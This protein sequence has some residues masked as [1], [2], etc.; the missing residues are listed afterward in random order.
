MRT[1]LQRL[2]RANDGWAKPF[3]EFNH[4]WLTAVFRPIRPVKDLLNGTWLGH[5]LHPALTDIPIGAFVVAL[6]L[7]LVGQAQGAFWALVVGQVA[8]LASVVACAALGVVFSR[9]IVRAAVWLLFTL[10][11][12][13][14]IYFLLGFEFLGTSQLIVYVGGTMV[15][16][17]F[18]VMLTAQGPFLKLRTAPV[19]WVFAGVVGG[20][21]FALLVVVSL[22]LGKGR[23]QQNDV[24]GVSPLGMAFLGVDDASPKQSLSGFP[25]GSAA[26]KRTPN[27]YLLPFEVVS[28]HLLVVLIAAAYLARAKRRANRGATP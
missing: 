4:R 22:E 6:V 9:N 10:I 26:P 20:G 17:I 19:E 13:S 3:G 25:D 12:V 27:G 1:I 24:P 11:G 18:G 5:P 23:T 28:V 7:D 2:V 14:M 21:L 16:V 15:L 8:F